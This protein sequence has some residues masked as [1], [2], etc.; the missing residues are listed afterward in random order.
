MTSFSTS[1]IRTSLLRK[2]F[3]SD[4]TH[5]EMLWLHVDGKKTSVR[6]RLS[7]GGKEYGSSLL[8]LM[9][10]QLHLSREQLDDL[11]SCPMTMQDYVAMLRSAGILDSA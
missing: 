1:R 2:G 7:H 4:Q 5:H 8:G 3:V 6:T 9:A 11:I 10:R